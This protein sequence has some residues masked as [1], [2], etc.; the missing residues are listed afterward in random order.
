MKPID[1]SMEDSVDEVSAD[2]IDISDPE[3][4]EACDTSII[5][6][7]M[8]D[9]PDSVDLDE[10]LKVICGDDDVPEVDAV[11]ENVGEDSDP[12]D[13]TAYIDNV[14]DLLHEGREKGFVTYEDIEKHMP[15]ISSRPTSLTAFT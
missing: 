8:L 9:V 3:K 5:E 2:M 12:A 1:E 13:Y 4:G 10:E 11:K 7:E 15:R 6:D 14:R